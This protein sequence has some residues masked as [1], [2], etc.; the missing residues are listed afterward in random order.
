MATKVISD[1]AAL[2]PPTLLPTDRLAALFDP[3]REAYPWHRLPVSSSAPVSIPAASQL[4]R[5]PPPSLAASPITVP[6]RPLQTMSS[7]PHALQNEV[8]KRIFDFVRARDSG[9]TAEARKTGVF[10]RLGMA[11][12]TAEASSVT[13]EWLK[14]HDVT[15]RNLIKD[16][17]VPV[18]DLYQAHIVRSVADLQQLGFDMTLL[19]ANRLCLNVQQVNMCFG[20]NSAHPLVTGMRIVHLVHTHPAFTIDELLTLG[21]TAEM[22]L[23]DATEDM[24]PRILSY[25]GLKAQ[26]WNALELAPEML[27]KLKLKASHCR[28]MGAGWDAAEVARLWNLGADWLA[29]RA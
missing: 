20:I 5:S 13:F 8:T 28:S 12:G 26:D 21:V 24:D 22:L 2:Y 11:L 9:R 16:C 25:C 17:Q 15:L 29:G 4:P 1:P 3:S 27:R 7:V 18:T 10:E 23:Q 19:T 6:V 14:S